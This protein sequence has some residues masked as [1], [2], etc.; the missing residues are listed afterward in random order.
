MSAT[1]GLLASFDYVDSAV[2]AIGELRA[3]GL[4]KITAYMPYPDPHIEEAL[5]YDQSPV[6]VWALTGGLCGAAG[7]FAFTVFTSMDW[8][9]VTGGKPILSMPA[10]VI[11]S[12]EMMVL[13]GVLATVI[14]LFVNSR[15]PFIKPMV[16][17]D[18][19]FSAGRFGIYVTVAAD[20]LDQARGILNGQ[21]P[22]EL[23]EDPVG[24]THAGFDSGSEPR[25]DPVG[26][27]HASSGFASGS[28]LREDRVGMA[29]AS[30]GSD[31]GDKGPSMLVENLKIF[32]VVIG[33][34]GI[35][36][37]VANSIPQVQ[38]EVPVELSFGA[39]V[40]TEE[41]MASGEVLF[42]GAGGCTTCH[43]TGTRA[44]NLLT[45]HGGTG[46]I[47]VRCGNR[48][49]GEEC[50]AYLYSSM[51]DPN[52]YLVEGFGPIM[53]DMRRSLSNAQIWALVAYLESLGGEVTVTGADIAATDDG[54]SAAPAAT[55]APAAA[56]PATTSSDPLEIMRTNTCLLC[57]LFQGEGVQMGPPFDGMGARVDAD[58]IRES[59]LDPGAGAS[60][61]YE[62]F[63]GAMPPIFG[64]QLTASQL[65]AVVRFLASQR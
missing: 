60:E 53:P 56:T 11:I 3:A 35:F 54:S 32:A 26:V 30:S 10:Y 51:V 28:E 31:S 34:L 14:G 40:S 4:K 49:A 9:L 29:P 48:V 57:H 45:D 20:R 33:T 55:A 22:A 58:Y 62:A 50:K 24:V 59:I 18:P 65:E 47:G 41:L 12:F 44:P 46:L 6:R 36:T 39:D 21:D 27:A 19:E 23:R 8:P 2:N 63:L 42:L 13:F 5:G 15:L 52:V 61:G 7:G 64:N 16:V 17:Y 38:S 25:E 1:M 37:L 43:G